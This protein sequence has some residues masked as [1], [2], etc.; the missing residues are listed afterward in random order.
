MPDLADPILWALL[1]MT[2]VGPALIARFIIR[3]TWLQVGCAFLLWFVLLS[4]YIGGPSLTGAE[5]FGWTFILS[6]FF[7]I[8]GVPIC[9]II[10]RVL[11]LPYR[12]FRPK[13]A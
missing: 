2:I 9:A 12:F 3:A 4:I 1:G 7:A 8:G 13:R 5:W 11:N 6:M 10:V